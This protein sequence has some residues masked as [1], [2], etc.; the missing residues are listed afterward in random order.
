MTHR[1]IGALLSLRKWGFHLMLRS[2]ENVHGRYRL[3]WFIN[4]S[5]SC[6]TRLATCSETSP[7]KT[8]DQFCFHSTSAGDTPYGNRHVSSCAQGEG[9]RNHPCRALC[10]FLILLWVLRPQGPFPSPSQA[11]FGRRRSGH[12]A[13]VE[14]CPN[15]LS[16]FSQDAAPPEVQLATTVVATTYMHTSWQ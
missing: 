12:E 1:G 14:M 13:H 5:G 7:W 16:D 4:T 9:L 8:I 2:M 3:M 11:T 6:S 10:Y 15:V